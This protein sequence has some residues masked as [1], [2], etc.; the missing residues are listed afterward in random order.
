R[1]A[2]FEEG[3]LIRFV[4]SI[5]SF[6]INRRLRRRLFLKS[7]PVFP[8]PL[9]S[10]G[11][12]FTHAR[13]EHSNGE[14]VKH[15]DERAGADHADNAELETPK[16]DESRDADERGNPVETE[17]ERACIERRRE[18]VRPQHV[19]GEEYGEI[20]DH[21]D[22]GRGNAGERRGEFNIAPSRFDRRGADENE[23]KG[24]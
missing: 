24:G 10:S 6:F 22:H 13:N 17:H 23:K 8:T 12:R 18:S 7:N 2:S 3:G 11:R 5:A 20:E 19:I 16:G 4:E 9:K 21:A 1:R 15:T 14:P